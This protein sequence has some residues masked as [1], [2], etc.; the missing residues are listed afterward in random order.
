MSPY[1]R[2]TVSLCALAPWLLVAGCAMDSGS[3]SAGSGWSGSAG[4]GGGSSSGGG[5]TAPSV[6]DID[7]D[8]T[9]TVRAGDGVGVFTEYA[10]GGHWHVWWTCDTH[11]TNLD[12]S[13]DVSASVSGGALAAVAAQG[14][15]Q[16]VS[17]P[18]ASVR[19]VSRTSTTADGVT[20]DASAGTPIVLDAKLDDTEQGSLLFFVQ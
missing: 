17:S 7:A 12:C 3:S 16:L 15:A 20:F 5:E 8:R 2:I 18:A 10:R 13:F 4:G 19:A 6:V 1:V 14:G 9:M 11:V